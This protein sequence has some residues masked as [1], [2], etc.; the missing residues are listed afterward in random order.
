MKRFL[1]LLLCFLFVPVLTFA[2]ADESDIIGCWVSLDNQSSDSNFVRMFVFYDNHIAYCTFQSFFFNSHL[3][4]NPVEQSFAK[5]EY[6][7][8]C[9]LLTD[10]ET[11][12]ESRLYLLDSTCIS[13]TNQKTGNLFYKVNDNKTDDYALPLNANGQDPIIG[14][15][16][17]FYDKAVTP[18]MATSFGDYERIIAIYTFLDDGSIATLEQDVLNGSGEPQYVSAGKW[19][20]NGQNYKYSIIGF[21]SGILRVYYDYIL[22]Q[23][24]ESTYYMKLHKLMPMDPYHDYIFSANP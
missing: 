18:E 9:I 21:G 12:K 2:A 11:G 1:S 13:Y 19:E 8:G 20:K 10:S 14:A 23:I 4:K 5:W 15:W 3:D 6:N 22:L 16:Y 7:N 17:M 24:N